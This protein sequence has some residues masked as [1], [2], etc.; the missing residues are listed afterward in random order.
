MA[1]LTASRLANL[2]QRLDALE[3]RVKGM[4]GDGWRLQD[5]IKP[6]PVPLTLFVWPDGSWRLD[7]PQEVL[8]KLTPAAVLRILCA[9]ANAIPDPERKS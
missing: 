5:P 6:A 9:L 7:E 4:L 8:F 2:D 1:P 3:V